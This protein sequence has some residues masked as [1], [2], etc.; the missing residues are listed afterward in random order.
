MCKATLDLCSAQSSMPALECRHRSLVG[1]APSAQPVPVAESYFCTKHRGCVHTYLERSPNP[2]WLA[3][4]VARALRAKTSTLPPSRCGRYVRN[5]ILGEEAF[6]LS[7]ARHWWG[8]ALDGANL[9]KRHVLSQIRVATPL[10]PRSVG[11]KA[12]DQECYS[13][14]NALAVGLQTDRESVKA[15]EQERGRKTA[16]LQQRRQAGG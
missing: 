6:S 16:R 3:L 14:R 11:V 12:A 4:T 1:A 2:F 8:P 9:R 10:A 13:G 7:A 15:F 5:A